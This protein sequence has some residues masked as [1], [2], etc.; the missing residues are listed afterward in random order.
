MCY[1]SYSNVNGSSGPLLNNLLHAQQSSM[2]LLFLA[3]VSAECRRAFTDSV[4]FLHTP[5]SSMLLEALLYFDVSHV[6]VA[7]SSWRLLECAIS[8]LKCEWIVRSIIE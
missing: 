7:K 6:R 8:L 5:Q 2:L 1:F 3:A 4:L